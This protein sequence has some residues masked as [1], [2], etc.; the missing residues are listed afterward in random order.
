MSYQMVIISALVA[1]CNEK[2][3]YM[4]LPLPESGFLCLDLFR[5]TLSQRFLF[6]L[7]LRVLELAGLLF[8]KLADFHLRLTVVLVVQFLRCRDEVKHVGADEKRSQFAEVAV[9]LILN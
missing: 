7:E 6:L 5:E 3:T 9:V 2:Q 4:L 1:R 8:A